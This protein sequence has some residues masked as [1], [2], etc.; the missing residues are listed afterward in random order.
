MTR[1]QLC[2]PPWRICQL[3]WKLY[4]L[5]NEDRRATAAA[6]GSYSH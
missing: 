1:I 5:K 2:K 6:F 3:Y 4:D